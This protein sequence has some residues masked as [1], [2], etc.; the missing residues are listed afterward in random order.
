MDETIQQV[1]CEARRAGRVDSACAAG[2]ALIS[3]EVFADY[4]LTGDAERK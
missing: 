3:D 1:V 4:A 2:M